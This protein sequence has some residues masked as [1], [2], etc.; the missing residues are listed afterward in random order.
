MKARPRSALVL[1][2]MIPAV[3]VMVPVAAFAVVLEVTPAAPTTTSPSP[4]A[5]PPQWRKAMSRAP[6]PKEGCFEMTY[7]STTWVEVPCAPPPTTQFLPLLPGAGGNPK[8]SP[9]DVGHGHDYSSQVQM[10]PIVWAE[11]SFP[12]VYNV[13][14]KSSS[15]FSLQLN[16]G[17]LSGVSLCGNI[18]GCLG[19]AQ[20]IYGPNQ[21][22]GNTCAFI[23]YW[24]LNY[25]TKCPSGWVSR[26]GSRCSKNSAGVAVPT[27]PATNLTNMSLIGV[28]GAGGDAVNLAVAGKIYATG[29]SGSMVNLSSG[30]ETAEFNIF[31]NA[32]GSK[33]SFADT[34]VNIVVQTLTDNGMWG[35]LG[36]PPSRCGDPNDLNANT[37]A[38]TN[39]LT[40][41]PGGCCAIGGDLQQGG[42]EVETVSGIQFAESSSGSYSPS[43]PLVQPDPD[44]TTVPH[45]FDAIPIGTDVGGA[46]LY[47]CRTPYQGS[48]TPG[49]T[50]NDWAFCDIGYGGQELGL[51]PYETLVAAWADEV[52]GNVPSNALPFGTDSGD[53]GAILYPC[54]A[55]VD[56]H[57]FQLGKVRPDMTGCHIGYFNK[58][59]VVG[60][61]QVLT[62]SLPLTTQTVN[63]GQGL[64]SGA[65]VG[66]YQDGT[67]FYVC[68]GQY[69]SLGSWVPGKTRTDWTY[70]MVAYGGT[71]HNLSPY[72]V[73]VPVF[74]TSPSTIFVAGKEA[75]GANLGVCRASY[76]NS[77]QVGKYLTSG[78]CDFGVGGR[79]ISLTSGYQV[80]SF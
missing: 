35:S 71:E 24:L 13:T 22:S 62:S 38:E 7:P 29:Q 28:A 48:L 63:P 31:G 33:Y 25:G 66:G 50:R 68:Q 18:S 58:E 67:P 34:N 39:N 40:L 80:L 70:C 65:L 26:G 23:Q 12:V 14:S 36:F 77:T 30:W 51:Q 53:G 76:Q 42:T 78:A 19:L 69:P 49:K 47:S 17:F 4:T 72:N 8:A 21:C 27:Q 6:L 79:E 44:W 37:T 56:N 75:N 1:K 73:L 32:G 64:P 57:G 60:T 3:A 55:Y 61:Y 43:C 41:T 46:I 15:N 2:I 59:L 9:Y 52:N 16:S 20:F 74:K 10:W 5:A 11:G 54:R 45:P